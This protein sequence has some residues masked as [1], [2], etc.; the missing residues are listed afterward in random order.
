MI[1]AL[2]EANKPN[3]IDKL[4]LV[5]MQLSKFP[6]GL[7]DIPCADIFLDKLSDSS[8][9]REELS[10]VVPE[11][12]QEKELLRAFSLLH[13]QRTE[14]LCMWRNNW[15]DKANYRFVYLYS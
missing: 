14:A 15:G 9:D 7:L 2:H 3:L 11:S 10:L 12:G 1:T 8:I 13:T 5:V 6:A 4:H